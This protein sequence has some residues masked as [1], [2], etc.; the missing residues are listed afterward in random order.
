MSVSSSSDEWDTDHDISSLISPSIDQTSKDHADPSI[1]NF[2]KDDD[3]WHNTINDMPVSG[4]A[5]IVKPTTPFESREQANPENIVTDAMIIVDLTLLT[6]N[7]IHNRF[8]RNSC[9]DPE[10]SRQWK[11]TIGSEYHQYSSSANLLANGT[12]IPCGIYVW[13]S[14]LIQLRNDKAGHYFVPIFPPTI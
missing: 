14:A 3:N 13:K 2:G 6:N 10:S 5:S 4:R 12:V 7:K 11:R 1:K 8:D 9:N